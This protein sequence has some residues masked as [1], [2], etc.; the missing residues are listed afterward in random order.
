[1][2]NAT[3]VILHTNLGRAPLSNA[4]IQA[5]NNVASDYSTLEYDLDK[6]QRGSRLIHAEF[7]LQKLTGAESALIVNN[8]AYRCAVGFV[9]ACQ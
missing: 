1:M 2:I 9:G 8:N 3:G 4:T 6:G 5:M 7:V